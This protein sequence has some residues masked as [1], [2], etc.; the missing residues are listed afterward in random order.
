MKKLYFR[1]QANPSDHLDHL[2]HVYYQ[3]V[4]Q[5]LTFGKVSD[6]Y[7]LWILDEA[8]KYC[9]FLEK[10]NKK[11]LSREDWICII[12]KGVYQIDVENK[13]LYLPNPKSNSRHN[14][15]IQFQGFVYKNC[16]LGDLYLIHKKS[17]YFGLIVCED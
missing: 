7:P 12:S 9:Q 15:R 17:G 11:K 8:S 13:I 10:N 6:N 4:D 2:F 3:V 5:F 1:I 14:Y 16:E